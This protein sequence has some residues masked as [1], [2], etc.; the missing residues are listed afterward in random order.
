GHFVNKVAVD[1][2]Q[3]GAVGF[4]VHHVGR[5]EFVVQGLGHVY[6]LVNTGESGR[7]EHAV[8]RPRIHY[9]S[10]ASRYK[11]RLYTGIRTNWIPVRAPVPSSATR[12]FVE[13]H[14]LLG[15]ALQLG[16]TGGG[17]RVSREEFWGSTPAA[18]RAHLL[19]QRHA[20]A[21]GGT[22]TR[23]QCHADPAGL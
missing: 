17:R 12:R 16:A 10:V 13:R 18:Q 3:T 8:S 6:L 23:G 20:S 2:Q 21:R 1:I 4:L 7:P 15:V 9:A 19:P 14:H 11:I 22:G 5:P